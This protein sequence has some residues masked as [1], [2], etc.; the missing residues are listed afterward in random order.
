MCVR[1]QSGE[2]WKGWQGLKCVPVPCVERVV[3]EPDGCSSRTDTYPERERNMTDMYERAD[4]L[5]LIRRINDLPTLPD[6]F[7]RIRAVIEDDH[8]DA[9]CLARV[10]ETDQGTSAMVLKMA[11]S[12][13]FNPDGISIARLSQAIARLGFSETANIAMTMS[14]FYGFSLHAD[15]QTIRRFWAHAYAVAV[16]AQRSAPCERLD[17]DIAFMAGLLHDIGRAV[18][19]MRVDLSYFEG[20][21]ASL[22]G[23]PLVEEERRRFGLDHAEAGAEIIC[24]WHLPDAIGRA[25]REHHDIGATS[26]MARLIRRADS[27]VRV[28]LGDISDVEQVLPLVHEHFPGGLGPTDSGP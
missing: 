12:A 11:N 6:Y 9:G 16:L 2:G 13:W 17:A 10:I 27:M 7:C 18:L 21:L 26:P 28:H 25:V 20:G 15:M 5:A 1:Q 14:L 23:E 3:R 19:G 4:T 22:Y 8:S 24:M